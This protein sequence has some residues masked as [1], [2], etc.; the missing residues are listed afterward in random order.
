[1]VVYKTEQFMK[2]LFLVRYFFDSADNEAK[3]LWKSGLM[4]KRDYE[5]YIS[6]FANMSNF[7]KKPNIIVHLDVTPEESYERIKQ[8]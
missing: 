5:T 1:M 2:T 8:R 3:M 7:M 6:L 4:E